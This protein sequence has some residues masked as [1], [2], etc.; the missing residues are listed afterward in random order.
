MLANQLSAVTEFA[1]YNPIVQGKVYQN[2]WHTQKQETIW[3]RT[4]NG[5]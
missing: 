3:N 2:V 4:I 1:L 5:K